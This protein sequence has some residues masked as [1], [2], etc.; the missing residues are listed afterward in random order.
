M[1]PISGTTR[2]FPV[3]GNPVEQVKAPT[4]FNAYFEHHDIDARVIPMKVRPELYK[5]TIR[6]LMQMENIGGILVSIPFKPLTAESVDILTPRARLAGCC[7]AIYRDQEGRIVGDIIDGEGFVRG[8]NKIADNAFRWHHSRALVVGCGGVGKAI[9]SALAQQSIA[10]IGVYDIH[11]DS[12]HTLLERARASFPN[13][14]FTSAQPKARGWQLVVNAST[15][16][17]HPDDPLPVD[18]AGIDPHTIVADCGMKIEMTRL[19]EQARQAGC[20]IQKG[21]E[22]M[23]EQA[24]LYMA[25]FGWPGID[26][27]AFRELGAL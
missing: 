18:L 25:L 5:E 2:I 14:L 15:L 13:T 16:G 12:A 27:A 9:V 6:T 19:L 4:I 10:E 21:K 23:I 8:L 7:N 24:P 20:R 1:I 11:E 26:V 22:M 3:I 17:M